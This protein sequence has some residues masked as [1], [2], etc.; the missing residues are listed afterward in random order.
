M[1]LPVREERE[2]GWEE[3]VER[4][5]EIQHTFERFRWNE[6]NV[7]W[8]NHMQYSW[9]GDTDCDDVIEF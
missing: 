3:G 4:E 9:Q 7:E 5:R 6:W 8:K 2:G 1:A